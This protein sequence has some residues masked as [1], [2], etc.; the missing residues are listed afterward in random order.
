M[1]RLAKIRGTR[2][3]E[4]LIN[5]QDMNLAAEGLWSSPDQGPLDA[6]VPRGTMPESD[7]SV[8]DE[9][10][11][12][13]SP[14]G[15]AL[16]QDPYSPLQR[17]RRQ[18]MGATGLCFLENDVDPH[19]AGLA[20][21]L[22][23]EPDREVRFQRVAD[24]LIKHVILHE[25][26]HNLGL[27]HNFEGTYDALNYHD[28]FWKLAWSSPEEKD[29]GAYDEYRHTTVMEYMSSKGLFAD[30]L[31]KYDEAAIRFSYGN[32]VAVF[33]GERIRPDL[34][35]GNALREWRYRSDYMKIPDYICENC[36]NVKARQEVL[37]QRTWVDFD[38]QDPPQ[39]EVPFLFCDN[40]YDRMTPYCATFDYGS[41]MREIFANYKQMWQG[42]YIFNNFSRDRLQPFGW[43]LGSAI[44]PLYYPMIF[45]S[46]LAQYYYYLD[47]VAPTE[48]DSWDLKADMFAALGS[49]LNLAAEVIAIPEPVRLCAGWTNPTTYLPNYYFQSGC[50]ANVSL[51][52]AEPGTLSVNDIQVPLG[53]ARPSTIRFSQDYEEYQIDM[54]GSYFDKA[55]ILWLLGMNRPTLLRF[56]YDLDLRDR[57]SVV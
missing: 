29:L 31:G 45:V 15:K 23:R 2:L 28:N 54:I 53:P 22:D 20:I 48:F 26:G 57:K 9:I 40:Y 51:D 14:L 5:W 30:F 25:I 7:R 3:E 12:R 11:E 8:R 6:V 10:M 13:A 17:H 21:E 34:Q 43:S 46:T 47:A 44:I 50:D 39:F 55:N 18:A 56:N 52:Y 38:P 35:G 24:R 36:N 49:G 19:W 41:N 33:N 32:Q 1:N 4:S 16:Y 27:A 42:Y 37:Q